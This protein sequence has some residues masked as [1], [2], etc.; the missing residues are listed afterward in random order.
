MLLLCCC[1]CATLL[2]CMRLHTLTDNS[3]LC[4]PFDRNCL[5]KSDKLPQYAHNLY[6]H[7]HV[8][9]YVCN[10]VNADICIE[11]RGHNRHIEWQQVTAGNTP[12]HTRTH[13]QWWWIY[14]N[15][16]NSSPT[17]GDT[18]LIRFDFIEKKFREKFGNKKTTG[19]NL[20]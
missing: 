18:G 3:L 2:F 13:S 1:Y 7:S 8:H 19:L 17:V 16:P 20:T 9:M 12:I 14:L 15:L 10:C 5:V 6:A 4:P 11:F